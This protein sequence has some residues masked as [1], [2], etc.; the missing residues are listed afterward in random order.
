M[1][2]N[3]VSC[4]S[5]AGYAV[6]YFGWH[7]GGSALLNLDLVKDDASSVAGSSTSVTCY[8]TTLDVDIEITDPD[9]YNS[10]DEYNYG[11]GVVIAGF[12]PLVCLSS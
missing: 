6:S 1:L 4:C 9:Y 12:N 10:Y 7:L 5:Y 2:T 3:I 11:I 8:A